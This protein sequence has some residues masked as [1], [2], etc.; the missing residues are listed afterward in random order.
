MWDFLSWSC[1]SGQQRM[2][3][4]QVAL[5]PVTGAGVLSVVVSAHSSRVSAR[6]ASA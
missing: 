2:E 4:R 5:L 1:L 6:G 3:L